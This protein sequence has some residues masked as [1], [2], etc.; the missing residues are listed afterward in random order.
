MRHATAWAVWAG[1]GLGLA[2]C[3]CDMGQTGGVLNLSSRPSDNANFTILLCFLPGPSHAADAEG[4]R[5]TVA[6]ATGWRDLFVVHQPDRSELYRGRYLSMHQAERD[7]QQSRTWR[8]SRGVLPFG[9]ALVMPLPPKDVGPPEWSL[10]RATGRYTVAIAEFYDVPES[11][12]VGRR[13]FAVQCCRE[14]RSEGLEAYYY[15]GPGK[16]IVSIGS[17]PESSYPSV[18]QNG[19]TQR[20]VRDPKIQSILNRFPCLAVNGRQEV[21]VVRAKDGRPVRLA[22]ASYVMEIPH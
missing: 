17:F 2:L 6:Q 3:G 4:Y 20:A 8:D 5:D 9:R 18:N 21:D 7:L 1:V 13:D 22:T 12:Y 14:L 11:S 19:V 15:H 16:S 10:K